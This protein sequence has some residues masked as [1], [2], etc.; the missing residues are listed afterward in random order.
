MTSSLCLHHGRRGGRTIPKRAETLSLVPSPPERV[1]FPLSK[2]FSRLAARLH[3]TAR[4]RLSYVTA[5]LHLIRM[6]YM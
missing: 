4:C 5:N 3:R 1:P 6:R 2:M